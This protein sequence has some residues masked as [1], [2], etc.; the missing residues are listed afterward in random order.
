MCSICDQENKVPYEVEKASWSL[1]KEISN[2]IKK[3]EIQRANTV[4]AL[5][6]INS[7]V[8]Y[9]FNGR[10]VMGFVLEHGDF[11]CRIKV[12]SSQTGK[13]YWIRL[14]NILQAV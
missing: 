5:L 6:P 4:K 8:W 12:E 11:D 13:Q 9:D 2:N 1:V 14:W 10:R 7:P 3:L